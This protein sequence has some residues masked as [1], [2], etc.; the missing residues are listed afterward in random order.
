MEKC[1]I[2]IVKVPLGT[3]QRRKI[4]MKTKTIMEALRDKELNSDS[5]LSVLSEMS[6]EIRI[7]SK[8]LRDKGL[9]EEGILDILSKISELMH[10]VNTGEECSTNHL[11]AL[12]KE[13]RLRDI[14]LEIGIPRS[15][16]G[17]HYLFK[18]VIL[19]NRNPRQKFTKSL[20]PEVAEFFGIKWRDVERECRYAIECAWNRG[21]MDVYEKYFKNTISANKGK[22]TCSEFIAMCAEWIDR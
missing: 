20:Y 5:I 7:T 13:K 15:V 2:I 19:Y 11:T 12:R 3:N 8:A 9:N 16:A 22:P 6:E 14:F 18:S 4:D 17:Y 1:A 10:A 21:D